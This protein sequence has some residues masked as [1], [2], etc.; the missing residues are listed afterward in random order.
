MRDTITTYVFPI[1]SV[2]FWGV[3]FHYQHREN[4]K[5]LANHFELHHLP[6]PLE[7]PKLLRPQN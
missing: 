6:D 1:E 7:V 2:S 5:P 3:G 4:K